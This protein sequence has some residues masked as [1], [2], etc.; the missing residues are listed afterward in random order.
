MCCHI[1]NTTCL[2]TSHNLKTNMLYSPSHRINLFQQLHY[3]KKMPLPCIAFFLKL[4]SMT[5]KQIFIPSMAFCPFSAFNG[6]SGGWKDHNT[7]SKKFFSQSFV[8]FL[9]KWNFWAHTVLY[10]D[11][12][13]I[14]IMIQI[15]IVIMSKLSIYL[16][17]VTQIYKKQTKLCDFFLTPGALWSFY[18][19]LNTV[20]C[21]KQTEDYRRNESSFE[22]IEGSSKKKTIQERDIF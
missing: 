9:Y 14:S 5:L 22:V 6:V 17:T 11:A 18:P 3:A 4:P 13:Q 12:V 7:P 16:F 15:Y 21:W 2:E 10:C 19:P 8:C 1:V 20:K